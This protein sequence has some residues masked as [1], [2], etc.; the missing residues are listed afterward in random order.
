MAAWWEHWRVTDIGWI[1]WLFLQNT[2]SGQAP[3]IIEDTV[4]LIVKRQS[5]LLKTGRIILYN[6]QANIFD[7]WFLYCEDFIS[8]RL[9]IWEKPRD[10]HSCIYMLQTCNIKFKSRW[11]SNSKHGSWWPCIFIFGHMRQAKKSL[12]TVRTCFK[13]ASWCLRGYVLYC[14]WQS[15]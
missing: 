15:P 7:L 10:F 14:M 1:I 9:V 13:H 12:T 2:H 6:L 11:T 4:H 3:L 8:C 5:K